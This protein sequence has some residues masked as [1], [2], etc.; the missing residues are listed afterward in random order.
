M[1]DYMDSIQEQQAESLNRQI[2][3][4]RLKPCGGA[5]LVC[6]DCDC[7]IPDER[8]A[9]YPSAIRCFSCQSQFELRGIHYRGRA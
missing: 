8:R 7:V 2:N 1:P 5:V 9:A 3:A 4:V 6:E